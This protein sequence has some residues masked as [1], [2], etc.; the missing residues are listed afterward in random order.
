MPRRKAQLLAG[1]AQQTKAFNG[2]LLDDKAISQRLLERWGIKLTPRGVAYLRST[3][4]GIP[5]HRD[6]KRPISTPHDVDAFALRRLGQL[7]RSTAEEQAE[8]DLANT[9]V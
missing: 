5:F 6:G 9:S 2:P 8:R 3:G 4:G 1:A 7:R